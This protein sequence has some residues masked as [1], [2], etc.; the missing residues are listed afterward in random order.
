MP[1]LRFTLLALGVALACA[2][3]PSNALNF[4]KAPGNAWIG[5]SLDL[6]VPLELDPD[7]S[8]DDLCP[9]AEV[10]YGDVRQDAGQV[11]VSV[12][13]GAR[14]DSV[15]LRVRAATR[16]DEPVVTLNLRAGCSQKTSRRVVLLADYPVASNTDNRASPL[17]TVPDS[18]PR[19][20]P[21]KPAPRA[22][23][24][25]PPQNDGIELTLASSLSLDSQAL[26]QLSQRKRHARPADATE[27]ASPL[28]LR[29]STPQELQTRS[30]ASGKAR[31]PRLKLDPVDSLADRVAELESA[32]R[33]AA[34][35]SAP[36]PAGNPATA[37]A[38]RLETLQT[39]LKN[40]L[41]QAAQ[42]ERAMAALRMRL[43]RSEYDRG[44]VMLAYGLLG[45]IA[46][47]LL[48]V[49]LWWARRYL[50]PRPTKASPTA[51]PPAP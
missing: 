49:L 22:P 28:R 21:L 25:A 2:A 31:K 45:L 35:A 14:A 16:V 30:A 44:P 6:S 46:L 27:A 51:T 29:P 38:Q 33:D 43:E 5:Q 26:R 3:P 23:M 1:G 4:G 10:F 19:P 34:P 17:I 32:K 15:T 40:L 8:S 9:Q 20:A 42:N 41:E 13:P 48:G 11:R 12:E 50:P 39:E 7:Q 47:T 36:A 18:P 37:E 24:L